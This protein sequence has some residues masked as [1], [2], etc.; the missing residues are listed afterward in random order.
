MSGKSNRALPGALIAEDLRS[1]TARASW[2]DGA[3]SGTPFLIAL[4]P[5]YLAFLWQE[6]I[7]ERRVAALY[8]HD[9]EDLETSAQILVLRG[10]H[11]TVD[12]AREALLAVRNVPAPEKPVAR[13]PLRVWVRSIYLLLVFGGF[14]SAEEDARDKYAHW[15]LKAALGSLVG[16][17]I[18]I[19]T[20]VLPLTFMLAMAWGCETH[21]RKLGS[22][23]LS[24]YGGGSAGTE[25]AT[26]AADR[27][28]EQGRGR[29][30]FF[31]GVLMLLSVAVPI[32]FVAYADH[33]RQ[34]TGVNLLGILGALVAVSLVIAV[35]VVVS[36]R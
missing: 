10:V 13:R 19:T 14:V 9:P 8:G 20:W 24:F 22:R 36:R 17:A 21:A 25:A 7:M 16:L 34:S 2:V 27:Q 15:R 5:G 3:V 11:P 4:I 32:A 26:A 35:T 23:T 6:G 1:G 28:K 30:D 33:V 18:F 29:R 12:A 31:R